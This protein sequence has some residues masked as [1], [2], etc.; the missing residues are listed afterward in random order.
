MVQNI[1]Y[2]KYELAWGQNAH[3]QE[4]VHVNQIKYL[5]KLDYSFGQRNQYF[6]RN[7]P[8]NLRIR[9]ETAMGVLPHLKSFFLPLVGQNALFLKIHFL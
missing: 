5:I 4:T 6:S 7:Y 1:Q 2:E 8:F 9:Q 3:L